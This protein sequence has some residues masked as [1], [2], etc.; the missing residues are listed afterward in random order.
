MLIEI[1]GR[2]PLEIEALAC[3]LNGTLSVDGQL[4]GEVVD[5]LRRLRDSFQVVILTAATFGNLEEVARLTGITPT[6]IATGADKER[7]VTGHSH[8]AA[9]GN[10]A[11]DVAML[12][13][14]QFAVAVL[15]PEGTN[16]E[17]LMA[18]DLVVPSAEAAL[19]L[20]LNPKR[21]VAALR[22]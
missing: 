17:A 1:P 2:Q 19:G 12:R 16:R 7:W 20:F 13:A 5:A 14:A 10:G 11:N 3:D 6:R 9:I 22:P 15:G 4:S 21:L 8:V 18:A